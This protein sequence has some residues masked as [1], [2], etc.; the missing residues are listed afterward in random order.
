[1]LGCYAHGMAGDMAKES[2]GS[3]GMIAGD[4]LRMLPMTLKMM[5][6]AG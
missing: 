4:M 1:V 6:E 5:E 3:R 2:L